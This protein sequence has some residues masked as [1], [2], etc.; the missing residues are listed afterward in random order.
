QGGSGHQRRRDGGRGR[1]GVDARRDRG[2]R[3]VVVVAGDDDG[4]GGR[5]RPRADDPHG[6]RGADPACAHEARGHG[7]E[8]GDGRVVEEGRDRDVLLTLLGGLDDDGCVLRRARGV[9]GLVLR[10]EVVLDVFA[11]EL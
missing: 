1:R 5:G 11:D 8:D 2:R 7:R 4:G 9:E 6:S 3:V 10:F